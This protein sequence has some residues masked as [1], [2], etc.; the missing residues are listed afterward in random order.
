MGYDIQQ[1]VYFIYTEFNDKRYWYANKGGGAWGLS[2][3]FVDAMPLTAKHVA[4][5]QQ[6]LN[7]VG[8]IKYKDVHIP[9][10]HTKVMMYRAV[11]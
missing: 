11:I 7:R 8:G 4:K 10:Y 9:T 5:V 6:K 3:Y 1:K 2:P